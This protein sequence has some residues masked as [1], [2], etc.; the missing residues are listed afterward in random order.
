MGHR[1]LVSRFV[2]RTLEWI[3]KG[4]AMRKITKALLVGLGVL[5]IART[6]ETAVMV[7]AWRSR[8]PRA[9]RL[10]KRYNKLVRPITAR[11]AGRSGLLVAVHHVGRR[12]G[13]PY[14]TPV[15]AHL[16]M[17]QIVIPLP[18]GT[19]VDWLRNL[20]AAGR[21][22][23]DIKGRSLDVDRPE[24]V[25]IEDVAS[26]LPTSMLRVVR[27]NG[28]CEALRMRALPAACNHTAEPSSRPRFPSMTIGR[29]TIDG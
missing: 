10:V 19:D 29:T 11:S 13:A 23:V 24:V 12:S 14:T 3:D 2:E 16:S 20:Q 5:V 27:L 26:L 8:N 22:V 4:G 9:L 15:I 1:P 21:G 6:L 25:A 17:D 7:C 28:A 18:Y